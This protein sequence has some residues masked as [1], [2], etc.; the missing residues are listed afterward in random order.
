MVR[1][2]VILEGHSFAGACDIARHGE[3]SPCSN[4]RIDM[5]RLRSQRRGSSKQ[6]EHESQE[7]RLRAYERVR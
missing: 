7:A 3:T 1:K 5:L 2:L 4:G 6:Y